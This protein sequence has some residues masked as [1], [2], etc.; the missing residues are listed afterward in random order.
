MNSYVEKAAA[1]SKW[2]RWFLWL[3]VASLFLALLTDLNERSVIGKV[4]EAGGVATG[5]L[6]EL[7]L[8]SDRF[9]LYVWILVLA[10]LVL[11]SIFYSIWLYRAVR[12]LL[13]IGVPDFPVTPGWAVGYFFVPFIN[14]YRPY[15]IHND[16]A[17]ASE[18]APAH[19][20][21]ARPNAPIVGLWWGGWLAGGLVG[22]ISQRLTR[23]E[24]DLGQL[25]TANLLSLLSSLML[26]VSAIAAVGM[27]ARIVSE[28]SRARLSAAV[29][30]HTGPESPSGPQVPA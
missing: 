15:Q 26:I 25:S 21:K 3:N 28:Q 22:R 18:H 23:G 5:D 24:P 16:L 30:P 9:Q 17:K 2:A 14:L 7:A 11:T 27:V 20:W 13:E 29:P 19:D 8:Q 4:R 6:A 1:A 10:A 12:A